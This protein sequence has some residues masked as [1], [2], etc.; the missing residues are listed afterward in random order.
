MKRIK[1]DFLGFSLVEELDI[2]GPFEVFGKIVDVTD[3]HCEL[4]IL[5][6]TEVVVCKH[7]LRVLRTHPLDQK[8]GGT[9][10]V[11]PGGKGAREPSEERSE[12]VNFLRTAHAGYTLILSV[13]T[14]TFLLHEAGMLTNRVCTTHSQFQE[15]LRQKGHTVVPHRVVHDGNVITSTGVTSG[16]DASLYVVTLLFSNS[17]AEK[18]VQRIEYPIPMNQILDAVHIISADNRRTP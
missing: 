3:C 17:V 10:L 15:E 14:G 4:A 2:V 7:G 16:I 5:A 8:E 9:V 11:V 13:C 12:V 1:I 18:I 6:P